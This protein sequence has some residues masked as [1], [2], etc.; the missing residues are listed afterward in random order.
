MR[1]SLWL[2]GLFGIATILATF[3]SNNDSSITLFWAPHR[4]DLSLN[5]FLVLLAAL[6]LVLHLAIRAL[7]LL[8]TLPRDAHRWRTQQRERALMVAV[9]ETMVLL[10]S[11]RFVRA[12]KAA[13]AIRRHEL[14]LEQA[15][16]IFPLAKEIRALSG[17]LE[18]EAAHALQDRQDRDHSAATVRALAQGGHGPLM[19]GLVEATELRMARWALDD[20]DPQ[21]ALE[22]LGN[23]VPGLARRT[24]ALRIKLKAARLTNQP[25]LALDTTRLLTNHRGLSAI[26]A[27]GLVQSLLIECIR[28]TRDPVQL[29][30]LWNGL[31]DDER[32][33]T[34]LALAAAHQ[35]LI[36]DVDRVPTALDWLSGQWSAPPE[37]LGGRAPDPHDIHRRDEALAEQWIAVARQIVRAGDTSL[38][39]LEAACVAHPDRKP[40]LLLTAGVCFRLGLWGK[41]KQ[42][43]DRL[44]RSSVAT[45]PYW[46]EATN[47]L[48]LL[49]ER[50]GRL[51]EAQ[52]AW[53]SAGLARL[54]VT[55]SSM[56]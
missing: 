25:F 41:S 47:G 10:A 1:F 46:A 9:S 52:Q 27:A 31:A 24:I 26:A 32:L 13:Q 56:L 17:F 2:I 12:R 34:E 16:E 5:F 11:G 6:F 36:I 19:L 21:L 37:R 20:H 42:L 8:W 7:G 28:L 30:A 4:L 43:M 45:S 53:R 15:G 54:G 38:A 48:A 51:D 55:S 22:R 40:L 44:R 49:A 50:D 33:I 35:M 3:M 29:T 23:M 14:A 18:A 39:A